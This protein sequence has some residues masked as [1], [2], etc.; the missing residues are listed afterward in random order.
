MERVIFNIKSFSFLEKSVE[1]KIKPISFTNTIP[2]F[3]L[4]IIN[5][6]IWN[7]LLYQTQTIY[8]WTHIFSHLP[9]AICISTPCHFELFC[10]PLRVQDIWDSTVN[11]TYLQ[12]TGYLLC[13][14]NKWV[15]QHLIKSVFLARSS[16]AYNNL[17]NYF[18]W[19]NLPS[20]QDRQTTFI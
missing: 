10:F 7:S 8:P 4:P 13:S 5:T 12:V 17:V 11:K 2:Q 9:S 14:Q 18:T 16:Y 20:I 19:D 1:K 3:H 15:T 6:V